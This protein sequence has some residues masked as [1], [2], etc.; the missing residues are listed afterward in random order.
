MATNPMKRREHNAFLIGIIIGLIFVLIV[1][2]ILFNLYSKT[3]KEFEQYKADQEAKLVDVVVA[4]RDI[5]SGVEVSK[6][7]F[8]E[9]KVIV[10][11]NTENCYKTVNEMF[12]QEINS[13]DE[14]KDYEISLSSR[15]EIPRGTIITKNL[16]TETDNDITNDTRIK[17]YNT[18][19]LPSHLEEGDIIDVRLTLANGQDFIVLSKKQVY[20]ADATTVWLKVDEAEILTLNSAMVEAFM[21][22]GSKLYAIEYVDAGMQESAKITYQP[23]AEVATLMESNPNITDEAA[24]KL[25]QNLNNAN[26]AAFREQYIDGFLSQYREDQ[27]D[28]VEAGFAEE[29]ATIQ[30]HRAEYLDSLNSSGSSSGSTTS[31][32][33]TT[34][35][36]S[37]K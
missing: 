34:S 6:D 35:G 16:V 2:F 13:D 29:T 30:Q 5:E 32:T 25:A 24:N 3:K 11:M 12:E 14:K 15:L 22:Q 10:D 26:A 31:S 19:V 37:G 18:F 23:R 17:E 36:T 7:D 4:T 20:R 9:T 8:I 33:S 1:G 21:Y 27:D 28:S